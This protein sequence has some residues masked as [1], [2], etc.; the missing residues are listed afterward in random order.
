MTN[1]DNK[2]IFA[3]TI[4]KKLSHIFFVITV[5]LG[6]IIYSMDIIFTYVQSLLDDNEFLIYI[7]LALKMH[8]LKYIQ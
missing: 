8:K 1:I 2:E 5:T 7:K 6:L 3:S 4:R